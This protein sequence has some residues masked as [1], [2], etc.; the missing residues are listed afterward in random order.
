MFVEPG[1]RADL[2]VKSSLNHLICCNQRTKVLKTN[3]AHLVILER[4][5]GYIYP[6]YNDILGT[7]ER[8]QASLSGTMDSAARRH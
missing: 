3:T 6:C 8:D 7:K 2:V 1:S 5:A 4:A